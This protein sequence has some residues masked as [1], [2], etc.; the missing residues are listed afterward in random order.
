MSRSK[1][2]PCM[3]RND[4]EFARSVAKLPY[5]NPFLPERV[6]IERRA[7]GS[8]FQE[9][10]LVW[11]ADK[12]EQRNPNLTR[13]NERLEPLVE[14]WRSEVLGSL[15]RCDPEMRRLYPDLALYHLYNRYELGLR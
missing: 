12:A 5:R 1:Y 7:L 15:G 6:E 14:R 11:H 3:K 13:I 4:L 2:N 10:G 8:D 9:F